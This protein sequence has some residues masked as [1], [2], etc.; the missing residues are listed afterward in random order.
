MLV[1]LRALRPEHCLSWLASYLGPSHKVSPAW[2]A[3]VVWRDIGEGAKAGNIRDVIEVAECEAGLL[4]IFDL[5]KGL[6]GADSLS[7]G[8]D[9]ESD[10]RNES[11][12]AG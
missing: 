1:R 9:S 12:Y 3:P 4:E 10:I 6:N 5:T 2:L 11:T 7:T 8:A